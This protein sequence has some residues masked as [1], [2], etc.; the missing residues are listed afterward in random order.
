LPCDFAEV[1]LNMAGFS[2]KEEGDEAELAALKA[3]AEGRGQAER[4]RAGG[5]HGGVMQPG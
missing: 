5:A 4:R 3:R 2:G 1:I